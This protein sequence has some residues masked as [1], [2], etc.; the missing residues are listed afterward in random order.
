[1]K[2]IFLAVIVALMATF[3]IAQTKTELKP[4]D[5]P[6]KVTDYVA[7]SMKGFTIEKAYK[8]EKEG[9]MS[10]AVIVK[11]GNEKHKMHFD[12]DGNYIKPAAT[13]EEKKPSAAPAPKTTQQ[14]PTQQK[15]APKT[16]A[17]NPDGSPQPE[18]K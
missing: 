11:K 5:L 15:P 7:Q 4:A 18:G 17:T 1:M 3:A 14:K 2:K 8:N 13:A 6:K 12:K 9:V 10:Y 16:P